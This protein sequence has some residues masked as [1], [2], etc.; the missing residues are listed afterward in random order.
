VHRKVDT[1]KLSTRL[2]SDKRNPALST[3]NALHYFNAG[4][5]AIGNT[6][7]AR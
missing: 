4:G 6:T 7:A 2:S 5:G 3:L 1:G